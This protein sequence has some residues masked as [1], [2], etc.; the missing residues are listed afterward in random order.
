MKPK[1]YIRADSNS[2][3][4]LGHL[5]R[6]I[7]LAKML[8]DEFSIVFYCN[9]ISEI[10]IS[11][12]KNDDFDLVMIENESEFLEKITLK[13]IVVLDGY[14]FDTEYQRKVKAKGCVLVCID[15]LH[16]K[17]FVADLIINHAPGINASDYKAQPYTKFALGL[18]YVLL[19]PPFL[20][21]AKKLRVISRFE[22]VLI[23]FGGSDFK[24]LTLKVLGS[25][26][27]FK[28]FNKIIVITGPEYSTSAEFLQLVQSD[29]RIRHLHSLNEKQMLTSMLEAELAI[30]PASGILFEVLAAGCFAISGYYVE[31][32]KSIY[33][34]FQKANIILGANNFM[35][36]DLQIKLLLDT[37]FVV[38]NKV[39]DGESGLKVLEIFKNY[40]DYSNP[41]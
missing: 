27:K 30:V 24:N 40:A 11:E 33:T 4:G 25:V 17:D 16:D 15:D 29:Y 9:E 37:N 19:R 28:E 5:M 6:C 32:Q 18:E 35:Q 10:F 21:Q 7:A 23:C 34:G 14:N 12:I 2:Q 31:N 20:E 22:N 41:N 39:I 3:V 8:R 38:M 26:I 13:E 1:L 36:I